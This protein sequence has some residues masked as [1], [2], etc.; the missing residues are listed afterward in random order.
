MIPQPMAAPA[1]TPSR[2][3]PRLIGAL[4]GLVLTP[5]GLWLLATGGLQ[6]NRALQ[7]FQLEGSNFWLPLLLILLSAVILATVC[8]SA[9]LSS[10]APGVAAIWALPLLITMLAPSSYLDFRKFLNSL[11]IKTLGFDPMLSGIAG[12]LAFIFILLAIAAAILRRRQFG[13]GLGAL[14]ALLSAVLTVAGLLLCAVGS[15]QLRTE[16]LERYNLDGVSIIS[17]LPVLSGLVLLALAFACAARS[18]AGLMI[19]G[20][21]T[22]LFGLWYLLSYSRGSLLPIPRFGIA[23]DSALI[24]RAGT[25]IIFASS[26]ML[27]GSGIALWSIRNTSQQRAMLNV[28][29][30]FPQQPFSTTR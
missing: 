15:E 13:N 25:G 5:L 3:M 2:T 23:I 27:I 10:L 26:L 6:L 16:I 1:P 17:L 7:R 20:V 30:S 22:F 21:V 28:Q 8:G 24:N 4:L 9:K 14:S 12:C 19:G 29:Q 11:Q 18:A